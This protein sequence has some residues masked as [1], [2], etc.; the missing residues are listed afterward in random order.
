MHICFE[1]ICS[2]I[3]S[4]Q[5]FH[6]PFSSQ[7]HALSV[8]PKSPF[9][10]AWI[11]SQQQQN[12]TVILTFN[13]SEGLC[14]ATLCFSN[15]PCSCLVVSDTTKYEVFRQS[16]NWKHSIC[17][18]FPWSFQSTSLCSEQSSHL[19]TSSHL[20]HSQWY[21]SFL[22]HLQTLYNI[23]F[24]FKYRLQSRWNQL[25]VDM[26]GFSPFELWWEMYLTL[27]AGL[28]TNWFL[29]GLYTLFF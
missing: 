1:Q 27:P 16:Y 3:F 7:L 12:I 25:H 2:Q 23:H 10:D 20:K 8:K 28:H 26:S 5:L 11:L 6:Y 18:C 9:S 13:L 17:Y 14:W 29:P 19:E 22:N 21:F 15:S 24:S 4:L